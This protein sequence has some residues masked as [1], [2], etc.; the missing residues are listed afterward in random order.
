LVASSL[1]TIF[2]SFTTLLLGLFFVQS[3]FS[4]ATM[5]VPEA[6]HPIP[7]RYE[8]DDETEMEKVKH[9]E[10]PEDPFGNEESGEVKYRIMPW[11]LVPI[12]LLSTYII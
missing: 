3:Q 2:T 10:V 8:V 9:E 11:W 12:L 7:Q 5:S 6:P 4:P 1:A